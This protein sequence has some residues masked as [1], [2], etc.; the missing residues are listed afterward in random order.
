MKSQY[1]HVDIFFLLV[2]TFVLV[3]KTIGEKAK[4]PIFFALKFLFL[5]EN[6]RPTEKFEKFTRG[7]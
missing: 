5:C 7:I 2:K 1:L 4:I 3:D 6:Y